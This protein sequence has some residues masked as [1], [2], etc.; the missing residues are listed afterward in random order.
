MYWPD[1]S[2]G[3][4]EAHNSFGVTEPA[5][6][7]GVADG[8]I[9]GPRGVSDLHP[10]GESES[11]AGGSAGALP[12]AGRRAVTRSYTL[13][14][15][16]PLNIWANDDVPEL[17]EGMFSADVQVLNYQPIAV[18]K[19][20]YW[21]SEGVVVGRRHQ[22]HGDAAAAAVASLASD[23]ATG[24]NFRPKSRRSVRKD[25]RAALCMAG[26]SWMH[27][28]AGDGGGQITALLQRQRAGDREAFDQLVS[29]VY[30]HLRR[31]RARSARAR[32]AVGDAERDGARAR[33][34]PPAPAR[35][36]RRL[37]GTRA[38][39]R[40]RRAR[41][42]AILVDH[43]RYRR[44]K[45]RAQAAESSRSRTVDG[46]AVDTEADRVLADR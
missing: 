44:A 7:W 10:A 5:L 43:A 16:E 22:R 23:F 37:A 19:A 14:A 28:S 24:A 13:R 46:F 41:D 35:D 21:N 39:L 20:L 6:R 11:G 17:G 42:A 36:A 29:M 25:A 32:V 38:L 26:G 15:D 30:D 31:R 34:L 9:G 4:R 12:E 8:R 45:K 18:E 1:I 27:V 3:W 40:H 2:Q 33:S